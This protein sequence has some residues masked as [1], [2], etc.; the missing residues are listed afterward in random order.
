MRRLL[1]ILILGVGRVVVA[2]SDVFETDGK[3]NRDIERSHRIHL[4]QKLLIPLKQLRYL[5]VLYWNHKNG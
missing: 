1:L 5:L 2:Q 3:G 4:R